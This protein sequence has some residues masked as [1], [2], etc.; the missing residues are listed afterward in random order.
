MAASRVLD[1]NNTLRMR[2]TGGRVSRAPSSP[3]GLARGLCFVGE[4]PCCWDLLGRIVV[5]SRSAS[6]RS[7]PLRL[8]TGGLHQLLSI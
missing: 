4:L 2:Q 1:N 7:Q 3:S 5:R 8:E 6:F